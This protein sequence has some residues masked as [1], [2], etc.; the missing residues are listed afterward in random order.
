MKIEN[1]FLELTRMCTIE[2]EHCLRGDRRDEYMSLE[3]VNNCFKNVSEINVLLLTGGEPLLAINQIKEIIKIIKENNIKV[4]KINLVTNGTVLNEDILSTLK[5]LSCMTYLD[6][7]MSYDIFHYLEFRRLGLL[8]KRN[9]IAQ[10]LNKELHAIDFNSYKGSIY[11]RSDLIYPIGKAANLSKQRLD[12]INMMGNTNYVFE[13]YPVSTYNFDYDNENDTLVGSVSVD[14][15]GDI[16]SFPSP[17]DKEDY[18]GKTIE[19][20][21]NN[22]GILNAALNCINKKYNVDVET[23]NVKKLNRINQN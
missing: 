8:E 5:E 16:V 2:C 18:E 11:R 3:T 15:N 6:I 23:N 21:V 22:Y 1:L 13:T 12:E 4:N 10:I 19:C 20:N 14:V 17:F 7:R 9:Q